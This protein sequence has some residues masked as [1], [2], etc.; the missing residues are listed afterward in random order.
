MKS[1]SYEYKNKSASRGAQ[2]V[3]IGIV[4][5]CLKTRS[6][7]STKMLSIRKPT[8]FMSTSGVLSYKVRHFFT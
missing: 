4:T 2:F 3:P 5:V 7:N 8:V 6:P 1:A